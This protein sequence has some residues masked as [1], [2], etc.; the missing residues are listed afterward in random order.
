MASVEIR[1]AIDSDRPAIAKLIGGVYAEYGDKLCLDDAEKDLTEIP[2]YY[3]DL[4]GQVVVLCDEDEVIGCHAAVPLVNRLGTCTFRRLYLNK[5]RR[6]AG[7]G[8]LLMQ[9]AVDWAVENDFQRIEFWSDTRFTRAHG[10]FESFGFVK[11]D[12]VRHMDDSFEPYSEYFF[13]LDLRSA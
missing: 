3:H 8:R 11:T 12:D 10:F 2:Q 4:G 5:S 13:Y 6:G 7:F 1:D 9:W